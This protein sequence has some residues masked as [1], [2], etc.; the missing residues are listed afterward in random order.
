[1]LAVVVGL[2]TV[3][4]PA[5][6]GFSRGQAD[7]LTR[8]EP[9]VLPVYVAQEAAGPD[10]PGTLVLRL[11]EQGDEARVSYALLRVDPPQL[12]DAD[13]G[14]LTE[15]ALTAL[16][17]DLLAVRGGA[18]AGDLATYGVRYVFVP[19]PAD[20]RL[21]ESLDGQA[22]LVRASAPQGG[23]LWRVDG[24]TA[25][26]RALAPDQRVDQAVGVVVPSGP[27]AVDADLDAPGADRLVLAERPDPG[28]Q[29]TLDGQPLTQVQGQD[30]L[31]FSLPAAT[32]RL[33]VTYEDPIRRW[34]VVAQGV[35]LLVLVLLMLPSLRRREDEL[36]DTVEL[37]ED[38]GVSP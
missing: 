34:L 11:S 14:S 33:Q 6:V 31:T 28:W 23:A 30:V 38:A 21:V 32:G 18:G 12:G 13:L 19:A 37:P 1:V 22:G 27:V 10:R 17:G 4:V 24:T 36:E 25:R 26:V 35:A 7:P 9:D 15:P 2:L 29:A 8:A 16:V 3:L 20:P 5:V